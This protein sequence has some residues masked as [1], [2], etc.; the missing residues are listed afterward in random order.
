MP[1]IKEEESLYSREFWMFIGSLV[2]FLGGLIIIG[3]TSIP[4]FNKIFGTKIAQPEDVLFSYNQLQ[5]FIAIVVGLLTAIGQ[6]LKYKHTPKQYLYQKLLTPTFISIVVACVFF[7]GIKINYRDHGTGFLVAIY[8]AI[9]GA[10]YSVLA[11]L[12]YIFLVLRGKIKTA[13]PSVAHIGFGLVLLGVLISSAKK[14]IISH[15]TTGINLFEKS[16]TEDPAENITLFK[17]IPIDMGK[18]MVTYQNDTMNDR[19]HQRVFVINMQDKQTK[20]SFNLYPYLLKNNRQME[21]Y[22]ATPN[23]KHFWNKDVYAYVSAY[24]QSDASTD[25][26]TFRPVELKVGDTVFY[27][28]GLIILNKVDVNQPNTAV[29]KIDSG[30][31]LMSLDLT[32]VSKEG[33]RYLSTPSVLIKNDNAQVIPDTVTAQSLI[34]KFNRVLND[35]NGKLEIG[36]KESNTLNNPITLKVIEFPFIT[37]LWIGVI[38][39]VI[40]FWMSVY[41]RVKKLT[42]RS[43]SNA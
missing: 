11:N 36:I 37:I 41:Q 7:V 31:L 24:S 15:N 4:V 25:T 2:L 18:Y 9:F 20:K 38:V 8:I 21:G 30:S 23:S 42:V 10:V 6:Y 22:G 29:P 13:G 33:S 39:M 16:K 43:A 28:K 26:A 19:D 35:K 1:S 14:N 17:S 27:S 3:K 5:I 12:G 34:V 40:G 32:V